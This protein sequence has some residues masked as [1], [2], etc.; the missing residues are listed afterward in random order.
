MLGKLISKPGF[1]N[2]VGIKGSAL[3]SL[4]V[5]SMF[6]K[7]KSEEIHFGLLFTHYNYPSSNTFLMEVMKTHI[8]FSSL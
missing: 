7:L 1:V 8:M 4:R 6:C 5:K 2:E 3:V